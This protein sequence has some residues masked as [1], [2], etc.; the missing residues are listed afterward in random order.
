MNITRVTKWIA[1][2]LALHLCA[3]SLLSQGTSDKNPNASAIA[4]VQSGKRTEARA[5]WWG[6][7]PA[8]TTPALQAAIRSGARRVVVENLGKPWIVEPI[9]LMSD[10]EIVFE[11]G[12]VVLAKRG[13]FKGG[14]DSLFTAS[15]KQN[16]TLI[17]NG[18]TFKMW[19]EDYAKAPYSK[20][21][22]RHCLNISSCTKVRVHGLTLA[23]SGGDG[24][25]LG[26]AKAGVPNR[27]IEIKD[28]ICDGNHR[29]GI[30]VI[31]AENLLIENTILKNTGGTAPMA[32]IDFEP[33]HPSE[34]LVHCVMRNC[35]SENNAGDGF[36]FALHNLHADSEPISI[37]LENSRS[38]GDHRS[39]F[40][41]HVHNRHPEG[42][43]RGTADVVNCVFEGSRQPGIFI[44]DNPASATQLRFVNTQILNTAPDSPD[45]S[46]ITFF[47]SQESAEDIGGVEFN[48]CLV[49]DP[50]H[51]PPLNHQD[52]MGSRR[53]LGITG[54]LTLEQ[55]GRRQE[56]TLDANTLASWMPWMDVRALPRV[57]LNRSKLEP[58]FADLRGS[59]K[60]TVWRHRA[61]AEYVLWVRSGEEAAF[62]AQV[63]TVGTSPAK[64]PL[65]VLAPSGG[66]TLRRDLTESA[67]ITFP[68]QETGAYKIVCEAAS[69]TVSIHSSTQR[70]CASSEMRPIHFFGT[71]GEYFF[72][73]PG[74]TR[75]FN[76]KITGG[77]SAERV[78]AS[79]H[80]A[81]GALVESNDNIGRPHRFAVTRSPTGE[82]EAW[83]I[84]LAKPAEGVL[85]DFY[86]ELLG[87][88]PLLAGSREALLRP[89]KVSP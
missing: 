55:E 76:L 49:R 25:Y 33:N 85:E 7:D 3:G 46:P 15:L 5:A 24:I 13:K 41:W 4:E 11:P 78:K 58:A 10:Q 22:W 68:A 63:K 44:A 45:T 84:R 74:G 89:V 62:N 67:A 38:V 51:R 80:D 27:D 42:A 6:F 87:L 75:E 29:Q 31:S 26:V 77:N 56:V 52:W 19:R 81:T 28:V 36:L 20:A 53:L 65:R 37:R 17:G 21:E 79:L 71:S 9:H 61:H 12:V 64:I 69:S 48:Q 72:W 57:S 2:P 47:S 39:A 35:V 50:L 34:R 23:E 14:N 60:P 1:L 54:Q 83:S 82:G 86:V 18:A 59:F 73:V 43:V 32:G 8:D 70:L 16:I 30:S 40:R 66:E 88:P